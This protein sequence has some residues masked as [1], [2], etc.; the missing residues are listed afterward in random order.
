M[1]PAP[2]L[3]VENVMLILLLSR[4]SLSRPL[5]FNYR[6]SKIRANLK[7]INV[8]CHADLP[9]RAIQKTKDNDK[10]FSLLNLHPVR[11]LLYLEK[12]NLEC[13]QDS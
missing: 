11:N 6:G 1:L 8:W 9:N 4:I 3:P 13:F 2:P 10:V 5:I 12:K 7:F